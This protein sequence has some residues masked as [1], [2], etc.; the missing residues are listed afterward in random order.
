MATTT[1]AAPSRA[2]AAKVECP[3]LSLPASVGRTVPTPQL[4]QDAWAC[5][6]SRS[7]LCGPWGGHAKITN[8]IKLLSHNDPEPKGTH[9][10]IENCKHNLLSFYMFIQ[11]SND[12]HQRCAVRDNSV[13]EIIALVGIAI[14]PLPPT[15]FALKTPKAFVRLGL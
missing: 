13:L 9:S 4:P 2:V 15:F 10:I 3:P 1:E 12:V 6:S 8:L 11:Q 5:F 14:S 7:G